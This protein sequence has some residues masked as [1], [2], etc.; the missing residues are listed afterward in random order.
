MQVETQAVEAA[1]GSDPSLVKLLARKLESL[2]R[3]LFMSV[4]RL[5][6]GTCWGK[7]GETERV[8]VTR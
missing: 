1:M 4:K 3:D 2:N 5:G 6:A 8:G 7:G